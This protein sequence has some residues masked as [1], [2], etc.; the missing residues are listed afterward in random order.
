MVERVE[1][2]WVVVEPP[3]CEKY[4]GQSTNHLGIGKI[5]KCI[6]QTTN[7]INNVWKHQPASMDGH[8]SCTWGASW[9]FGLP[10]D[11]NVTKKRAFTVW[12]LSHDLTS[13]RKAPRSKS[14]KKC[15]FSNRNA[16][17]MV[18]FLAKK[19]VK[20]VKHHQSCLRTFLQ[21]PS[22]LV[23]LNLPP[24]P[25]A[26]APSSAV[27]SVAESSAAQQANMAVLQVV[28]RGARTG[29]G[30]SQWALPRTWIEPKAPARPL[31][32]GQGTLSNA[33]WGS[34]SWRKR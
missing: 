12:Y 18:T 26:A 6:K 17:Q 27:A 16:K 24:I 4:A 34:V 20:E 1:N 32:G 31:P 11:G 21:W 2:D 19:E 22:T 9:S 15:A 8:W 28:A 25:A 29:Q 14:T 13:P 23:P 30:S 7:Q 5:K 10:H 3:I 33:I